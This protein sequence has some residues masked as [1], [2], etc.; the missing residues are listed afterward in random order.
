MPNSCDCQQLPAMID[1]QKSAPL[2]ISDR[3][4]Q[5]EKLNEAKGLQYSLGGGSMSFQ[6]IST[7]SSDTKRSTRNRA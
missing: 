2:G 1:S 3:A 6:V 5:T 4:V 7:L